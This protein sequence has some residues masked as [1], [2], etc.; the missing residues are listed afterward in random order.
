MI[1][2]RRPAPV[3]LAAART[4]SCRPFVSSFTASTT[5]TLFPGPNMAWPPLLDVLFDSPHDVVDLASEH[6]LVQHLLAEELLDKSFQPEAHDDHSGDLGDDLGLPLEPWPG[7]LSYPRPSPPL[8][9]R[10]P[11]RRAPDHYCRLDPVPEFSRFVQRTYDSLLHFF[12]LACWLRCRLTTARRLRT[13]KMH[14]PRR[15]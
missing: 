1:H 3:F 13:N 7:G 5:M 15:G 8:P 14:F 4:S 9:E 6:G 11:G 10:R 2:S 12:L